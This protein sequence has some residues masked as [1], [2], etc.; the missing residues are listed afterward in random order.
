MTEE[1]PASIAPAPSD[2]IRDIV[3][4]ERDPKALARHRDRLVATD[5]LL[6]ETW[7]SAYQ[8]KDDYV[9]VYMHSLRRK[10]ESDPSSPKYLLNE[11]GLEY[12]LSASAA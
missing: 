3:A 5:V 11:T 9:R 10:I 2:F 1:T 6:K 4:G 12:R 8:R 7:G